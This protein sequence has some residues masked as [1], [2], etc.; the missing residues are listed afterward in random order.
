MKTIVWIWVRVSSIKRERFYGRRRPRQKLEKRVLCIGGRWQQGKAARKNSKKPLKQIK[1]LLIPMYRYLAYLRQHCPC[2]KWWRLYVQ[3]SPSSK[4]IFFCV[5]TVN[6]T[7]NCINRAM[8]SVLTCGGLFAQFEPKLFFF[9]R[10]GTHEK[11]GYGS[12]SVARSRL[13]Y[14]SSCLCTRKFPDKPSCIS[15]SFLSRIVLLW[16]TQGPPPE[17]GNELLA[18]INIMS[19]AVSQM[20]SWPFSTDLHTIIRIVFFVAKTKRVFW[21]FEWL[22]DPLLQT[23]E[24]GDQILEREQTDQIMHC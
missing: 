6:D 13:D 2:G 4:A 8:R 20:K 1:L 9:T 5:I 24:G 15:S 18:T 16:N 23:S 7:E 10:E 19:S 3:I 12:C 21:C 17:M 11:W 14:A 22:Q